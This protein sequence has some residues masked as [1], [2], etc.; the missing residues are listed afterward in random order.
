V[1][2]I[3][4]SIVL[5]RHRDLEGLAMFVWARRAL[6]ALVAAVPILGLIGLFGQR[7]QTSR[8]TAG[9]ATLEVRAPTKLRG[10]LIYE[11]RF[12]ITA[13]QDVRDATL[14]LSS[15]WLEGMTINTLEPSPIGESSRNGSL[16]LDLGHVPAGDRLD[17]Y[18]QFQVNP[19]TLAHRAQ[20]TELD[21]GETPL[22][23]VE[24][25]ITVFP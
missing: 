10:G 12:R 11:A 17:F 9:A 15:G 21:D 2:E 25:T 20:K 8:A 14:V 6:I 19:T 23:R 22:A 18:M 1:P 16:A 4:D 24:R 5:K 13:R 3:P 7:P